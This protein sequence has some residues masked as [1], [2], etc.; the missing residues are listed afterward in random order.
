MKKYILLSFVFITSII[1]AQTNVNGNQ[2]GTWT[3]ANSPYQVTGHITVP[4]GQ[5]LTIEAGVEVNFQGYYKFIVD[6]KVLANGTENGIINFTTDNQSVG[7]GGIRLDETSDISVFTFCRIEYGKTSTGDYPDIHGGAVLLKNANAEFYN[8]I[9][10]DNDATG[11]DNGMGGAVYAINTGTATETLTK[12]IDCKFLQNHAYGEGGALKFTNDGHTEITRCE[13]IGNSVGYG[14]GAIM[15]FTALDVT[16]TNCLF[17]Q[18]YSNNSGGGAIKTLNPSVTLAITNCT[19]AYNSAYGAGEGGAVDLAYAD[20]TFTNSIIY[21]NSQTYGKEIN[22]GMNATADI[23]YC[24]VDMPDDATGSNNLDNV[25]PLFVN[26]GTEDFHLQSTSPCIDTGTDVGIAYV[27]TA[28]DMGCYEYDATVNID[29]YHTDTTAIYPNPTNNLVSFGEISNL[30]QINLVDI[31]G[32][33]IKDYSVDYL[34]N[35][36]NLS[37]LSTGVYFIRFKTNKGIIS[38]KVIKQ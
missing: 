10:A 26:I 30:K 31:T 8:C 11:D 7:W 23:N 22:I 25:N 1:Y 32:K 24:D 28:P 20:A 16:I 36:I 17:Y 21:G 6:G 14:G 4:A 27:G 9:F 38:K 13:F 3:L 34:N 37:N 2:S 33:M 35:T 29:D 19:F 18:N 15:F 12:F 5:I